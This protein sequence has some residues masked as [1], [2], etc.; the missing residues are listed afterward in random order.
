VIYRV[1]HR[2]T[3]TYEDPV[4]VSHHLVRLTPRDLAGQVTRGTHISILPAPPDT[5]THSD[6]FGNIQTFFALREPHDCLIVE[7]IS[8]LE[9]HAVDRPDFSQS[10]AWE[11]VVGSVAVDHSEEGLDAYQFVFGSQRVSASRELGDYARSS[12]LA[13]RPLLEATFDLMGRINR[14]F[15]FD[16]KATEVTTPVQDF[17]AKRRGVCQDFAHLQI[18]C[19]RSLGLPTRYISGYLRTLP[20]PG[21]PRLVG[22]DASH[23]WCSAWSP[24]SGWVDFDPTNNCV[25]TDGHITVAWGRDYSDVSPIHGVLL[26]G[27]KHTLDVGVDVTP[28]Q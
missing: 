11:T 24:G 9:V 21:K 23:A 4:S 28:L 6:Y 15:K 20:P 2:T 13:G 1:R 26:G 27:A 25:P 8:E 22:A 16:T 7:A 10:P 14:D 17:F 18:A 3:Y 12:F 5:A 19:M